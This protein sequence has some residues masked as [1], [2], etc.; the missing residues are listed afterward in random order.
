MLNLIYPT[1]S[2]YC[3]DRSLPPILYLKQYILNRYKN[4][5]GENIQENNIFK[6]THIALFPLLM[7]LI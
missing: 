4:I 1:V 3:Q 7:W 2:T 5:I 6:F